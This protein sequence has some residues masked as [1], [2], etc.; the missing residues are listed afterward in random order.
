[1]IRQ[2]E[3]MLYAIMS[4]MWTDVQNC[5]Y[6][7]QA[8]WQ[9]M[10]STQ[11]DIVRYKNDSGNRVVLYTLDDK[12]KYKWSYVRKGSFTGWSGHTALSG[13]SAMWAV[14]LECCVSNTNWIVQ[15]MHPPPCRSDLHNSEG[16]I[17]LWIAY[18]SKVIALYFL[19]CDQW[20]HETGP[21]HVQA[22]II[23]PCLQLNISVNSAS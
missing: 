15:H 16:F 10:L 2:A 11:A 23:K 12:V 1:M 14:Y 5:L 19:V 13:I 20:I 6:N 7:L 21:S 17:W 22:L 4:C 18:T 9:L 3:Q 8:A